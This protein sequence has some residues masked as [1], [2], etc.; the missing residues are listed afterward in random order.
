VHS[1]FF[2]RESLVWRQMLEEPVDGEEHRSTDTPFTLD[3]VKNEDFEHFLWAIY[4]PC[5]PSPS[6][7]PYSLL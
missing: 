5:V 4:N 6:C 2:Y 3:D 1:Y 7:C